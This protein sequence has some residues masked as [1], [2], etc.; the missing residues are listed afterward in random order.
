MPGSLSDQQVNHYRRDGFVHPLRAADAA[1]AQQWLA[2]LE[3]IERDEGGRLSRSTNT[4]P[5]LLLTWIDAIIRDP[6]VLDPVEAMLGPD[7]LCWASG[8]FAKQPGDGNFVSWH[9]DATY[10]GLSE[11]RS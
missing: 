2:Q 4:R 7:I 9:Q 11:T 3:A 8:F 10:W 1:Q 6:R 5:H